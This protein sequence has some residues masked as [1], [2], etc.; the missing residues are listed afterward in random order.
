MLCLV[1]S[2]RFIDSEALVYEFGTF[3]D[4]GVLLQ[5]GGVFGMTVG[6]FLVKTIGMVGLYVFL[7]LIHISLEVDDYY[8]C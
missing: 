5:G 7:S 2:G 1:N 3:Y 8:I 4:K 6:T